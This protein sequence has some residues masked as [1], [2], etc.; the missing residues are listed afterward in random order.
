[1][2]REHAAYDILIDVEAKGVRDLLG[3]AHT[4]EL[5]IAPLHFN[6]GC[7]EWREGAFRP[8]F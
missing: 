2:L 4:A 1:V 6:N 3:D 8:G 5:G 7:D